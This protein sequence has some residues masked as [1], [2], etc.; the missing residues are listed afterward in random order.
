MP[1]GPKTGAKQHFL[2]GSKKSPKRLSRGLQDER[3]PRGLQEAPKRP[4][5]DPYLYFLSNV[6]C[7]FAV[8]LLANFPCVLRGFLSISGT[9]G[10]STSQ[11]RKKCLIHSLILSSSHALFLLWHL[12]PSFPASSSVLLPFGGS[13]KT[14][15]TLGTSGQKVVPGRG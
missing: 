5:E 11:K 12:Q 6:P 7:V 14:S 10:F 4:Q 2:R 13:S 9:T 8:L 15:K 3:P 1:Q